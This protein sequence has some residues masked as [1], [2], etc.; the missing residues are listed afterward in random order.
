EGADHRVRVRVDPLPG[1]PADDRGEVG[2]GAGRRADGEAGRRVALE[3]GQRA[4]LEAGCLAAGRLEAARLE[5]GRLAAYR[6]GVRH[7]A[8][9]GSWQRERLD[10]PAGLEVDPRLPAAGGVC[11][12][13]PAA[14]GPRARVG[15]V[16]HQIGI[17]IGRQRRA[18]P[19]QVADHA[20]GAIR[21]DHQTG[22]PPSRTATGW[23]RS[24]TRWARSATGWAAAA[25]GRVPGVLA[26]VARGYRDVA[27]L[28]V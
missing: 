8:A 7:P 19:G 11:V 26:S 17:G 21:P 28:R 12:G 14:A 25:T 13:A 2:G 18:D 16:P 15:E 10:H 20:A 27:A 4:A 24:A 22:P 3:A 23:A 9:H 1:A 6:P 5:A